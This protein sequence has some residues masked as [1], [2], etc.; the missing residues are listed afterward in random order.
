METEPTDEESP[1]E[2]PPWFGVANV[3]AAKV[4]RHDMAAVRESIARHRT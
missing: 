1:Q 2:L 3:Y 4:K